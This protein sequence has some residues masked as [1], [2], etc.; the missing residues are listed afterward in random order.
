MREYE[1]LVAGPVG[2][3]AASS[4]PGF[5]AV[6]VPTAT[7]LTG[8]VPGA[9][10]VRA[11]LDLLR[12]HGLAAVDVRLEPRDRAAD[13]PARRPVP[14]ATAAPGPADNPSPSSTGQGPTRIPATPAHYPT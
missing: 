2:P 6:T 10:D 13:K 3:V 5:T 8:T 4:L 14:P 7:L 1:I 9:D 11:V 12:A